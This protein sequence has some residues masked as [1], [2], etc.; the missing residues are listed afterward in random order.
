MTYSWDGIKAMPLMDLAPEKRRESRGDAL[1]RDRHGEVWLRPGHQFCVLTLKHPIH[2]VPLS[3][4][5]LLS[6]LTLPSGK[7][8]ITKL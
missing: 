6:D 7:P 1:R 3:P 8:T 5:G 2:N 4:W